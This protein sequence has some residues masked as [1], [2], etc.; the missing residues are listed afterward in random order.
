MPSRD[1]YQQQA[2]L[3]LDLA[4]RMSAKDDALRLI[5]RANEYQVL[6]QAMP[7]DDPPTCAPP[8]KAVTQP[9]QQQQHAATDDK[10]GYRRS[11]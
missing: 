2:Q 8:P 7:A 11:N 6:A 10:N 4:A 9:M 5:E 3:L 1:Y